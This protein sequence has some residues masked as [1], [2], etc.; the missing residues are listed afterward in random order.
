MPE[1]PEVETTRRGIEPHVVGRT[2]RSVIV[3]EP[4]LRWR[5]PVALKNEFTGATIHAAER[6]AKYLLLGSDRGTLIL[7]LGMSGSLRVVPADTPPQ[8]HDHVD[9]VFD[10]GACLRLRDP[11]R[12]GCALWTRGDPNHNR[13]LRHLGPEPLEDTFTGAYLHALSRRRAVAVK[14]FLMDGRVVAGVG[15]IYANES[16]FLSGVHPRRKAGAVSL[17]RYER[18]AHSIKAVLNDA[19]RAGGTT[20]RDFSRSD[21]EPG[22]FAQQLEVYGRDG[23]PCSRCGA[24]IRSAVIGQRGTF[25]C[26][27][28]QR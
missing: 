13:L 6:R 21:G 2:V 14:S 15:N 11:R 9:I 7:H 12:F 1:L 24:P 5:V 16:L 20:L 27:R 4:R 3:R 17:L 18:I 25:Y 19:I 10:S 22:Y 8:T 26:P 23:A 28:C